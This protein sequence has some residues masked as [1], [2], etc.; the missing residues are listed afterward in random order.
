MLTFLHHVINSFKPNSLVSLLFQAKSN[1]VGLFSF[2]PME[3]SQLKAETK[4]PPG[5]L[6]AGIFNSETNF[7][8]SF[9]NPF[10][11]ASE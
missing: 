7:I 1:L 4:L 2:K 11:S 9:L 5:Y 6:T 3:S 10:S 8:T